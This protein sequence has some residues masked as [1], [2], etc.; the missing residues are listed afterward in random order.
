MSIDKKK[1]NE[2]LDMLVG[3]KVNLTKLLQ[4]GDLLRQ[5][6]KGLLERALSAE[7]DEHLGYRRHERSESDNSRNGI[8]SKQ[9]ITEDGSFDIEV[10]RDRD[11]S[12]TP[13]L[14]KKHQTRIAGL[15][16]KILYLYAKGMSVSDISIQLK[17]M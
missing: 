10:P 9:L 3:D 11:S 1:L 2:A 17:E 8:S 5:L 7:M 4:E 16:D 14:V 13:Q 6:R 12:F 15:D